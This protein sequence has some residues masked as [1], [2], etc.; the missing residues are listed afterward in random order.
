V[1]NANNTLNK[2]RHFFGDH[3]VAFALGLDE[4]IAFPDKLD[5]L[6][7]SAV[8]VQVIESINQLL[9][10]HPKNQALS[11]WQSS[12]ISNGD[13]LCWQ[14]E[15]Q[16]PHV[17]MTYRLQCGG[18]W[19][20]PQIE[21]PIAEAISQ[22]APGFYPGLLISAHRE[23][24]NLPGL[25]PIL[26]IDVLPGTQQ[27]LQF[28]ELLLSDTDFSEILAPP[29]PNLNDPSRRGSLQIIDSTGRGG[30]FQICLLPQLIIRN[31]FFFGTVTWA[32][33]G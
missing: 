19:I 9:T 8:Q 26:P 16:F 20:S 28:T 33:V 1:N 14:I 31:A 17:F 4:D 32:K 23:R 18:S 6:Q 22:M 10:Q 12:G 27:L 29:D 24:Y 7:C 13:I 30:G 2:I 5:T 25:E 21:D 3:A 11:D 15:N